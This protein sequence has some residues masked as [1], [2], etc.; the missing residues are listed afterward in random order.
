MEWLKQLR[1]K[2]LNLWKGFDSQ[3][4]ILLGTLF[5]AIIIG[6]IFLAT[7][8]G[9]PQFEVLYSNLSEK[10][11]STIVNWLDESNI[12]YKIEAG[13]S[14]ILVP[15]E[16]KYQARIDIAGANLS[17][18]GGTVGFELFDQ[19][20]LGMTE[21]EQR[22]RYIRA[23]S[24]EMERS[25]QLLDNVE[26]AV[27]KI[28]LPESSL[29]IEEEKP[30]TASVLV[31][32]LPG[33]KLNQKNVTAISQ[34]LAGGVEGLN[35]D[36]V[37]IVDTS[38]Y[39]YT[40]A[41]QDSDSYEQ[42]T[43]QQQQAQKE[44]E[45]RIQQKLET[46]LSR[47]YGPGNVVVTVVAEMNFD[48][49]EIFEKNYSPIVGDEGLIRSSQQYSEEYEGSGSQP[50]GVPGTET[51]I[52]EYQEAGDSGS[53]TFN[54]E[55]STINY[56]LNERQVQ[57]VIANNET[58]SLNVSVLI[59]KEMDQTEQDTIYNFVASSIGHHPDRG[60]QLTV[61]GMSFDNSL[62]QT[63]LEALANRQGPD[64]RQLALYGIVGLVV[65]VILWTIFRRSRKKDNSIP[66][67]GRLDAVV[68]DAMG[69]V[70]ATLN[71][72]E[73]TPE[74]KARREMRK[75]ISDLISKKPEDVAQLLKT[76]LMED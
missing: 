4:K 57:Q 23:V 51:N 42:L 59:N 58:K 1:D 3:T 72:H 31:K 30:A 56:E 61:L 40:D 67:G 19:T 17:P 60:D 49:R 55:D 50:I 74:E 7:W 8:A 34:L 28:S 66:V 65:L 13:G 33:T 68:G 5:F 18:T 6:M 48:R 39:S 71:H 37:T 29:F 53:S 47:M 73:L 62:E 43:S 41:Y 44:L 2:F 32:L 15:R 24:G 46:A 76:W 10:E 70:A 11:A 54:K 35:P 9:R 27:V 52:P 16:H 26:L 14:R 38:G 36:K 63:L 64:M 20:K 25:I 45:D 75:E 69:E 22:V 12:P 21:S